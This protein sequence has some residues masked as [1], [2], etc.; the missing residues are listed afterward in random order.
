M[1]L[2][3]WARAG[4]AVLGL[5][6]AVVPAAVT[7]PAVAASGVFSYEVTRRAD[8]YHDIP[9]TE[10]TFDALAGER[11]VLWTRN[12]SLSPVPGSTLQAG[13]NIGN[14]LAIRCR[15]ADGV[16][17][18]A[19]VE[20]GAYWASNLVPPGER[21]VTPSV[22]W[23]FQAPATGAYTCVLSVTSY[24]SIISGGRT[25]R[26]QVAAGAELARV[27]YPNTA[28]W[29][30]PAGDRVVGRGETATTLGYT[31]APTGPQHSVAVIQDAAISTCPVNSSICAGGSTAYDG[32]TLESW[33]EAQPQTPTGETCGPVIKSAV[34]VWPLSTAKHH[35]TVT[36]TLRLNRTEWGAC[37]EARVTLKLKHLSG[38]PFN[39]HSGHASGGIV[40]THGVAHTY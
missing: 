40:A 7:T 17:L 13:D 23:A 15:H 4:A 37:T 27:A 39:I 10:I 18:P 16:A 26:M 5:A 33:I 3:R 11:S 14:T 31:I 32:T 38:N 20:A 35:L 1:W 36:N 30:L 12:V 9:G 21:A 2:A 6:A 8:P 28:R 19:G 29:T 34:G 22:R 24:S 25:E